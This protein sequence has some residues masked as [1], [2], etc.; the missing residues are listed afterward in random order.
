MPQ[1][2]DNDESTQEECNKVLKLSFQ[3]KNIFSISG[4]YPKIRQN[5]NTYGIINEKREDNNRDDT[6][7]QA[8]I[9]IPPKT[10]VLIILKIVLI[11]S[12]EFFFFF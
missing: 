1:P 9:P 5:V 4:V 6:Y 10:N 8:T 3:F 7:F 2:N 11:Y 12:F